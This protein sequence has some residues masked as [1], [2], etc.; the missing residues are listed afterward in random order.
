MKQ[1]IEGGEGNERGNNR[2][3]GRRIE[4]MNDKTTDTRNK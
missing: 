4:E 2:W 3:S 1:Q